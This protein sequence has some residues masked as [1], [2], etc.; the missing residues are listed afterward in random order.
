MIEFQW[1]FNLYLRRFY[2]F[3]RA[4]K[5]AANRR[6]YGGNMHAGKEGRQSQYL[7]NLAEIRISEA[8]P[9]LDN[10]SLLH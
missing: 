6:H 9:L 5:Q 7:E 10:D 1:H 8:K 4:L 2:T 3:D